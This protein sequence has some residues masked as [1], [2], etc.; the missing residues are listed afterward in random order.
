MA[1]RKHIKG[2]VELRDLTKAYNQS[3]HIETNAVGRGYRED[4]Q[5]QLRQEMDRVL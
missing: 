2:Y 5:N 1:T 3:Q 4:N